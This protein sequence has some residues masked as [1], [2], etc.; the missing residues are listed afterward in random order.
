MFDPLFHNLS[1][2]KQN[3]HI[4]NPLS[5]NGIWVKFT[6]HFGTLF[7]SPNENKSIQE[8][9]RHE[10][11]KNF[12]YIFKLHTRPNCDMKLLKCLT[13]KILHSTSTLV[14]STFFPNIPTFPCRITGGE[15]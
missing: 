7:T 4:S 15:K 13:Q 14:L 8:T 2:I 1:H 10:H 6:R 5:N 3:K 12:Q 11:G 9:F